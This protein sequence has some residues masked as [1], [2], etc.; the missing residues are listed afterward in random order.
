L[1]L[2]SF[3]AAK[4]FATLLLL[5]HFMSHYSITGVVYMPEGW[6]AIQKDLDRLKQR[7]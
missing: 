7:A 1:G 5:W 2:F 6:D 4:D 3:A